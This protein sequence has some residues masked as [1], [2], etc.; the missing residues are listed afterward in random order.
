MKTAL[1]ALPDHLLIERDGGLGPCGEGEAGTAGTAVCKERKL[2]DDEQLRPGLVGGEVHLSVFIF[3]NP[4]AA[5]FVGDFG[6]FLLRIVFVNTEQNKQTL[7]EAWL[8][9]V[10]TA[11][12]SYIPFCDTS[13]SKDCITISGKTKGLGRRESRCYNKFHILLT[14]WMLMYEGGSRMSRIL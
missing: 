12:I 5:D 10:T 3:K 6:S 13:N 1:S 11:R 8:T 2:A 14:L 9:L 4:K 7:T